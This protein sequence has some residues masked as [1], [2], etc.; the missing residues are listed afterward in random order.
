MSRPSK[1]C[2]DC[3]GGTP[4]PVWKRCEDCSMARLRAIMSDG[5]VRLPAATRQR[6]KMGDVVTVV[7]ERQGGGGGE[8][9]EQSVPRQGRVVRCPQGERYVVQMPDGSRCYAQLTDL[10]EAAP[11]A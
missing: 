9:D 10:R 8:G 1:R 2:V 7:S 11:H 4:A 3:K 5:R 6:F